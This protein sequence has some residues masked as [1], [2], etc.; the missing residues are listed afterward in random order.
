MKEFKIRASASGSIMG[1]KGLGKTGLTYL[2]TWIKE[3][4]Y[5]RRK[6]FT[7]KYT[8]KGNEV[9]DNSIDFVAE[10]L[11]YGFLLKN[12]QHFENDFITGTPDIILNDCIIDVK[13]SWDCFTFPLLDSELPNSDYYYQAQCYMDLVGRDNYKVIYV[14]MDTPEHLIEREANQFCFNNGYE[15]G[16]VE[17]YNKFKSKMTFSEIPNKYKVKVF[18]IKKDE[19]VIQLI[20]NRVIECRKI[21]QGYEI[22]QTM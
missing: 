11:G 4:I 10:Q 9:E 22:M 13:N 16:D 21:I 5:N 3:Q 2:E 12:E 8:Q 14:L 20:K 18:D 6:D 7:S 1:V 15:K 17:V 19:A